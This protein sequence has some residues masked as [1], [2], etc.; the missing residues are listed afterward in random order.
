VRL[1]TAGSKAEQVAARTSLVRL[2]GASVPRA[3]LAEM[4]QAAGP[5]RVALIEILVT[6]RARDTIPD[7]LAMS[8]DADPAV[9]MAAMAA[10][11]QLAGPQHIAGMVQGVLKAKPGRERAAAEKA[12]MFVCGRISDAEQQ[13]TPLLAALDELAA[14]D[15][16]ALLPTLG[17][18]G[19]P[20]AR[21]IIEAAMADPDPAVH[22]TGLRAL[23]NWPDASI[24]PRLI[25][26]VRCAQHAAD[27]TMA[28][29]A[30]I[31]IAP[32][33]DGRP[34]DQRLQLLQQ[35]MTMCMRD[36]ERNLV[37]QRASAIRILPTLHFVIPYID[38]P[39]YAQQA[40]K[41]VVEL[42]HHRGLREPNKA[43]FHRALERVIQT[44]RDATV[45]ERARRYRKGQT[46]ARPIEPQS[47]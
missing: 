28:L 16:L 46:W 19:G 11:G 38:Q 10:L 43:E 29:R 27:R 17:R 36:A 21:T 35:A 14:A 34:A 31:R 5:L 18:V 3:I 42:A 32:L 47:R 30:L 45:V 25:E 4:D 23:C 26:L 12:V 1:L 2:A 37:L 33:P 15:R 24:A 40:C 13:A 22:Q 20:A 9:R 39:T 8:L 7:L 41:T 6:R 44:S